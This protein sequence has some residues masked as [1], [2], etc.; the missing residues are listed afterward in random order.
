MR[1]EIRTSDAT[2]RSALIFLTQ[3]QLVQCC[4]EH[5]HVPVSNDTEAK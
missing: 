4:T 2:S 1:Y 3:D 5:M